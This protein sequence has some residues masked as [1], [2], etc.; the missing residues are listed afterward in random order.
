MRLPNTDHTSRRWRIHELTHD[1]R[2]EDVW[3]V[4]GVGGAGDFPRLVQVIAS[5]DPSQSSSV[6]VRTLFAIRLKIGK[7]LGWDGPGGGVRSA[8][9][10]LRDRL[11]A[12][13]RDGP[14][15][16]EFEALPFTSLYLT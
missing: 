2:L 16:P 1:F 5:Y 4:P 11:P 15:G 8:V 6:T 9:P 13:L 10:T 14:S 12:D 3:K 7:L